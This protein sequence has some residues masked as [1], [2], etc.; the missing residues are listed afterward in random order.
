MRFELRNPL[1]ALLVAF[2][3]TTACTLVLPP[4]EDADGVQRCKNTEECRDL[5]DN[6]LQAA[7]FFDADQ[8]DGADGVCI[9]EFF[10]LS[11]DPNNFPEVPDMHPFGTNYGDVDSTAY[12]GTC[13]TNG[14]RGCPADNGNCDAGLEVVTVE[15]DGNT[16]AYCDDPAA[17]LKALPGTLALAGLDVQSQF[18]RWYFNDNNFVCNLSGSSAGARC[19][20][21]EAGAPPERGGCYETW[22]NGA[23]SPVYT[24]CPAD[25]CNEGNRGTA[26]ADFGPP[27]EPIP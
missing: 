2:A 18:C 8:P 4:D 15:V 21:C 19:R 9:A 22:L 14:Q 5:N 26:E 3:A 23:R 27:A 10:D 13:E 25:G 1:S 20:P 24:D 11:C 7:C 16:I 6:R 12:L 17:T